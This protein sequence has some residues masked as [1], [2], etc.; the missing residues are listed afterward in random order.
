MAAVPELERHCGSWIVRKKP[1]GPIYELFERANVEKAAAAGWQVWTTL[2]W[3]VEFNRLG[4][5][6][7]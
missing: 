4:R 5:Q 3:L 1:G 2:Q 7:D 6:P